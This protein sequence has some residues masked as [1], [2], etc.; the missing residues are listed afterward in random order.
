MEY[1]IIASPFCRTRETAELAFGKGNSV[2]DP[3]WL[4]IYRLGSDIGV[5]EQET[6]LNSLHSFL[7]IP[8]APGRNK[9]VVAHSFPPGVGLGPIPNMGTATVKPLG[10]GNGYEIAGYLT[11]AQWMSLME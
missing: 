3:F 7:E 1:P 10:K 11:L 4:N 8:P 6:I 2:V 5:L 9:F